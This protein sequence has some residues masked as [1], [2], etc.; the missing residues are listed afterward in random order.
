MVP[1]YFSDMASEIMSEFLERKTRIRYTGVRGMPSEYNEMPQNE[2][3]SESET[4]K[5][6]YI[7]FTDSN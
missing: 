1:F 7:S 4:S 3:S 5:V 6:T 2:A